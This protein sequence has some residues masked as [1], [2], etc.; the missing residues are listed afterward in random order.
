MLIV[1]KETSLLV[2]TASLC[3]NT[4]VWLCTCV[5]VYVCPTKIRKD[6]RQRSEN[7]P[8]FILYDYFG[9]P[10]QQPPAL[11][12]KYKLN[13]ILSKK[14]WNKEDVCVCISYSLPQKF[15]HLG[16]IL[17]FASKAVTFRV[18]VVIKVRL[19]VPWLQ[20]DLVIVV[21]MAV[22]FLKNALTWLL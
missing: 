4:Y 13:V 8:C 22:P 21:M 18:D 12:Y 15:F 11:L 1:I 5:C 3:V 20:R 19:I 6:I 17:Q 2:Y 16:L 14:G 9:L 10:V 7:L